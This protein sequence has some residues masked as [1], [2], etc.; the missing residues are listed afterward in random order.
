M[1]QTSSNQPRKFAGSSLQGQP[2]EQ[3]RFNQT[4]RARLTLPPP[5]II[6]AQLQSVHSDIELLR[7]RQK[8]TAALI[9]EYERKVEETFANQQKLVS[10]TRG[11]EMSQQNY[12]ALLQKLLNAKVAENLERRQ[13]GERFRVLD[14][15]NLPQKPYKP[16]RLSLIGLGSLV[17]AG[18]GIGF[19]FLKEHFRPLYRKTEDVHGSID[20][21]TLASISSNKISKKKTQPLVTLKEYDSLVAE[22][23]RILYTKISWLNDTKS[24]S[25]FA[26][27]SALK[28][29]GKTLTSLNLSIVAARD[30][31]KR[32]LL[33]EGDFKNP[34]I[35]S[36]LELKTNDGL[37]D[38]VMNNSDVRSS[39]ITFGHDNL[40]ILPVGRS[41]QNSSVVL[42]STRM[43]DLIGTFR[44]RYD[45]IFIDCPPILSLPDM[46]IIE[47][48]VDGIVLVVRAEKT[49]HDILAMASSSLQ[50]D[51]LFGL[52]LNDVR[53]PL[54]R[55]QQ[56][57]S[58]SI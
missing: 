32:V 31:G 55:Y 19:I 23:F 48:L 12:Q 17:S 46:N 30:F 40:S 1:G 3:K 26:I 7:E 27:S 18:L 47:R 13:K 21:P 22:Q 56:Y 54:K 28:N 15:A 39:I 35:A 53:H 34:K 10:I 42:S 11:Y 50:T 25:V 4:E 43:K 57:Y 51:K 36:Y 14:P 24:Y 44:E 16:N 2:P 5:Q 38:I 37:A 20:L 49:T 41:M 29:E 33:I 45:Y 58:T 6:K 52:V 9:K 8:R